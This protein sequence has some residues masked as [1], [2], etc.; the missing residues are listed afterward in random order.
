MLVLTSSTA[1][2][3]VKKNENPKDPSIFPKMYIEMLKNAHNTVKKIKI[4]K[5]E[6]ASDVLKNARV[7][8]KNPKTA[9]MT[10]FL[11][12][13]EISII[14]VARR[15]TKTIA[16]NAL[17]KPKKLAITP[18]TAIKTVALTACIH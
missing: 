18:E 12:G 4:G 1:I 13:N 5:L 7:V 11:I 14:M 2:K 17:L 9:S 10:T 8:I 16:C 6:M 15:V 3:Y